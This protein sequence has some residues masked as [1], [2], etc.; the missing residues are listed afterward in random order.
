[1]TSKKKGPAPEQGAR[2]PGE[3]KQAGKERGE[4]VGPMAIIGVIGI[5]IGA[6]EG[7]TSC[8][9]AQIA[10][11]A[12]RAELTFS[13]PYTSSLRTTFLHVPV[14]NIGKTTAS[15]VKF[16][17]CLHVQ[18]AE[19][20]DHLDNSAPYLP[21]ATIPIEAGK[22]YTAN[23]DI[24]RYVTGDKLDQAE[25]GCCRTIFHFFVDYNDGFRSGRRRAACYEWKREGNTWEMCGNNQSAK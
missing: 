21:G 7:F 15:N 5:A 14:T 22:T 1:M 20:D 16:Y 8:R 4:W 6:Y 24:S 9:Q 12:Q 25:S 18:S 10:E 11:V 17:G 23:F 3:K 13:P 19:L 2:R